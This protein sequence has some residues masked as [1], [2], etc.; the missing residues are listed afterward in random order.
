MNGYRRCLLLFA[1][2]GLFGLSGASCPSMLQQYAGPPL[3][4]VLPPA[5][6]LEQVIQVVNRNGSQIQSFATTHATL[7]GPGFP[8]LRANL[9]FQRPRRF[10]LRADTAVTGPELDIGSNE[11]LFW[12]WIKRNQPPVVYYCRHYQFPGSR[13]RQMIPMDPGWLVEALGV[14]GFDPA[15]PHQG[16]FIL[17]GDRLQ[18]RTMQETLEGPITKSTTIDASQGWVLGQ[19]VYDARGRLIARSVASRHRRD[20]LTGLVM[21]TVVQIDCPPVGFSMRIDLGNVRI[22]RLPSDRA[23]LWAMPDYQGSPA[24]DLGDPGRLRQQ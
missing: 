8:P 15:L 17:P 1:L 13:A 22:N 6:T 16:P 20:P 19:D 4:R 18:V 9:A 2:V 14:V 24:V 3:P 11:E 5:P 12:F 10:R 7:T 23:E 21:P